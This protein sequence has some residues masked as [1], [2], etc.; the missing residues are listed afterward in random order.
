MTY[1][2]RDRSVTA[3]SEQLLE[4]EE[5]LIPIG[6]HVFGEA[7]ELADKADLLR[8]VAS[9]DRPEHG[10]RSLSKLVAEGL[11]LGGYDETTIEGTNETSELIGAVVRNAIDLF[12]KEGSDAAGDWLMLQANVGMEK[13]RPTFDLLAKVSQQLDANS[14][15]ESLTRAL[16][17]E[18]IQ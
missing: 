11:E 5:R 7:G 8:M 3:L 17:G 15:L 18:Y 1:P 12:C 6:L 2:D 10:A 9:F 13:S 4:L 16:R 14:E